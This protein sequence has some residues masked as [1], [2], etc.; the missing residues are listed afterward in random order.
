MKKRY[1]VDIKNKFEFDRWRKIDKDNMTE[2]RDKEKKVE[3]ES[4]Y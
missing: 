2:L 1:N 4:K 3:N